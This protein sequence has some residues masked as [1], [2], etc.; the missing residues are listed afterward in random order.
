MPVNIH[1]IIMC[2]SC[3]CA[4]FEVT[5]ADKGSSKQEWWDLVLP[6]ETFYLI[7]LINSTKMRRDWTTV[8]SVAPWHLTKLLSAFLYYQDN[9]LPFFNCIMCNSIDHIYL[10]FIS[11][12]VYQ[13]QLVQA[14]MN[15]HV[16]M[17][18]Y[19]G[20]EH[21]TV[22]ILSKSISIKV[23]GHTQVALKLSSC[24]PSLRN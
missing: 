20:S 16:L 10:L 18:S 14:G 5:I 15:I 22:E 19:L 23:Q 7:Y 17:R 11:F 1:G 4:Y 24:S 13:F 2:L 6:K 21:I 9:K 3:N 8:F 12:F